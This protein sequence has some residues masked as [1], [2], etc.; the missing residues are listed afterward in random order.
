MADLRVF[1]GSS[2]CVCPRVPNA[3]SM[4]DVSHGVLTA[5]K[6][7]QTRA[8]VLTQRDQGNGEICV[9]HWSRFHRD[10]LILCVVLCGER[11]GSG[12]DFWYSSY[13]RQIAA[14]SVG[15]TYARFL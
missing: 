13:V 1:V 11:R 10:T 12:I 9:G 14:C 7:C 4:A 15:S 8:T 6:F 3:A 5:R 2:C